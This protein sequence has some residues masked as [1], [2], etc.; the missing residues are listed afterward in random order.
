MAEMEIDALLSAAKETPGLEFKEAK[1]QFSF[2]KLSEYCVAI[3]NEGGGWLVL[4]VTNTRPRSVVGTSAFSDPP[5]TCAKLLAKL[6]F[7]VNAFEVHHEN[8]R[9]LLFQIPSRPRG[10]P[11]HFEGRYLMRVDD[12]LVSM[13]PDQ[14]RRIMDEG[15]P[16]FCS[17]LAK[18]EQTAEQVV[19]LLDTQCYYDLMKLPYPA[20]RE[21]VLQRFEKERLIVRRPGDRFDITNLGALV[22][23]KKLAEFDDLPRRAARVVVYE[24][25]NKLRTKLDKP[26]V[27]GYAVGFQTL[28]D[29]VGAQIPQNEVIERAL[30]NQVKMAPPIVIR[31]LIANAMVHQDF[32]ESGFGVVVDVYTD[33]LEITS[34]GV[35]P[36]STQRFIDENQSRNHRL[37]DLMRRLGIC[38]EKGS[39][40]DKV[41]DAAE[42]FQLPAPEFR[43]AER[44]TVAIVYGP[45]RFDEMSREDRVRACFQHC[46]LRYLSGTSMTNQS[47]RDRFKLPEEKA[48]TASRIIRDTVEAELVK[49]ADPDSA[50]KRYARYLPFFA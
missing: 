11:Y 23:A 43:V 7:R 24:G 5:A 6:K 33:R 41:V 20:G 19:Q 13:T 42:T 28:V 2:E 26:G 29:F 10:T 50:S 36:I 16:D 48:E 9:V 38:E 44:H 34:P 35:P 45:R 12:Q 14:L 47:L 22:F 18:A 40:I 27:K 8:G 32:A 1:N 17:E 37:A 39:G 49:L 31:E 21:E 15:K 4:G 30:R 3:G 46:V 25:T